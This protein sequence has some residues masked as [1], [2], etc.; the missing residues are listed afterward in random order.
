[1]NPLIE[2][3]QSKLEGILPQSVYTKIDKQFRDEK[4]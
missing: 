3:P 2:L 1:M 4:S